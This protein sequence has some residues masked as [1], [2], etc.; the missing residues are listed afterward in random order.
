MRLAYNY[1]NRIW[2]TCYLIVVASA[3]SIYF[4]SMLAGVFVVLATVDVED[5]T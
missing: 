1:R 3:A 4:D 2:R 5:E